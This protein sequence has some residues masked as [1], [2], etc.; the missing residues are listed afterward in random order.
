MILV[1]PLSRINSLNSHTIR[2]V[3]FLWKAAKRAPPLPLRS[4]DGARLVRVVTIVFHFIY[5][6]FLVLH[7]GTFSALNSAGSD[8]VNALSTQSKCAKCAVVDTASVSVQTET[9]TQS[10]QHLVV[11]RQHYK[12][13][14]TQLISDSMSFTVFVLYIFMDN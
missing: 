2:C 11:D 12:R 7:P 14:P 10:F 13:N 4:Q 8:S 6:P 9:Q 1:C 3:L 5:F